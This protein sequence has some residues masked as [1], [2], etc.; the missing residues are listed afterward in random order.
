MANVYAERIEQ[1]R[2]MMRSRGWDAVLLTG[3]DP[4]GSEY[5]AERWKCVQWLT[6][7]TGEA[8]DVVVTLDHAG[9]W[10]D[11]RYFIQAV[12]QLEGT[13]V[14]LHK[15]R[16]PEQVPIPEWIRKTFSGESEVYIAL[17]GLCVGAC[18]TR[19]IKSGLNADGAACHLVSVPNLLDAI[20]TDRPGI[21]QTPVFTVDPGESRIE[22]L[23]RLRD[24]I[25][26]KGVDYVLLSALDDIAWTLNV[27]AS[28]IEYNPL[29]ISFLLVGP[30]TAEWFVLKEDVEDAGT[31]KTFAELREDGIFL[32]YYEEIEIAMSEIDGTVAAADL[33]YHLSA[34]IGPSRLVETVSP[35]QVWKAVKNPIEIEGF[36]DCHLQDGIAMVRFLHWLDRCM[37]NDRTVSEWD[38]AVHLGQLRAEI[39]GYQGDSFETISAYGPSAAL[40]H[41]ITPK[42]GA[43]ML[44]PHGLYLCDSGG[45]YLNGTTDITRTW[46]LGPC[47]RLEMEDYTL[48][49]RGHI[50]LA[51]AVFPLGTPG[52]RLDALA[53]EPLWSHQRNFGHGTGHGVG[54]FLGVHEGPQDVRQN[55][56]GVGFEAGMVVSDEPGIYREGL[57]GVRHE[58]LILCV[59]AGSNDFGNWLRFEPLTLC[60]FDTSALLVDMLTPA[61]RDWLNDYHALVYDRLRPYLDESD[62]EWLRRRTEVV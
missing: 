50:S 10:T 1:L 61:E 51:S 28:D 8:G 13:G 22:R 14:E 26:E 2:S 44:E 41:Y 39:P 12:Q 19:E 36:R 7:F 17:D 56:N 11:T 3:S 30:E 46:A 21:P 16:V 4:H 38:A 23:G 59:S 20:W 5:P 45:Q 49:L 27:R 37:Q 29:V 60:P 47:T 42:S 32:R 15:M 31:K 58:N 35:V 18:F 55:L 48:V 34:L 57:F 33:N 54:W 53:R 52:C 40:P 6:G 9:L 43:P 24:W 25:A 62:S